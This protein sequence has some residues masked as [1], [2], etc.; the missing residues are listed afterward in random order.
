MPPGLRQG[1]GAAART[2][3]A[4][5]ACILLCAGCSTFKGLGRDLGRQ[6]LRAT[7]E[8]RRIL[9]EADRYARIA[10]V[11]K[12]CHDSKS[13]D[14]GDVLDVLYATGV[15]KKPPKARRAR[16]RPSPEPFPVPVYKGA[17]RWPLRAGVVSSEFGKRWGKR[18]HGIDIAADSGVPVFAAA[19]GKVLYA[20]DRI[21]GYGNVVI[22]RHD[23]ETTTL[24]AH[25][26]SMKVKEGQRVKRGHVIATLGSTGRSTGP[27]V[28][29][30]IR[31]GPRSIDPRKR[32][33]K[34]RF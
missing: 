2:L 5:G 23:Q 10:K 13:L 28:H 22:L 8:G 14:E 11:L 9:R 15:L 34:G 6:A 20:G 19:P 32:L 16:R 3:A 1:V 25:N 12:K 31:E 33:P 26:R 21:K 30:E 18:H 27:H 29:F 24:Y 4:C 7:P 17:W